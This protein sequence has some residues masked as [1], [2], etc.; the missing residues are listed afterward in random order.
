M[1]HY[2][3]L[4]L[5]PPETQCLLG[6]WEQ[7]LEAGDVVEEQGRVGKTSGQAVMHVVLGRALL[8]GLPR[9]GV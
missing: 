1:L 3:K 5:S 9:F 4:N 8:A 2:I 7:S 6:G